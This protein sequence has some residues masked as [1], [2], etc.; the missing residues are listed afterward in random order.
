MSGL[1]LRL[2]LMFAW[3]Q[4]RVQRNCDERVGASALP[5]VRLGSNATLTIHGL[6]GDSGAI[7]HEAI[8]QTAGQCDF[9]GTE[10]F[11]APGKVAKHG[12]FLCHTRA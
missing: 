2:F 11:V 12:V 9:L 3:A 5:H 6:I 1:E 4:I 8:Q 10:E 7:Q